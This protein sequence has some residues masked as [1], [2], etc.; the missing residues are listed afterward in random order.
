MHTYVKLKNGKIMVLWSDNQQNE[1]MDLVDI[2]EANCPEC[3]AVP[4]L[5]TVNYSDI[6]VIDSNLA[7][8]KILGG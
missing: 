3:M 2:D 6:K 7:Y 5:T 8:L 1:T 4:F